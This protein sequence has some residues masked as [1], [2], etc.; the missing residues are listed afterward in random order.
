MDNDPGGRGRPGV[1][2]QIFRRKKIEIRTEI[3]QIIVP[4]TIFF[5]YGD[6]C[7]SIQ[8]YNSRTSGKNILKRTKNNSVGN[9]ASCSTSPRKISQWRPRS[10]RS[11]RSTE[12]RRF[13]KT[14]SKCESQ[15]LQSIISNYQLPFC[16][17]RL[18]VFLSI[19]PLFIRPSKP[20]YI[21]SSSPSK[22]N[23]NPQKH[24]ILFNVD[25]QR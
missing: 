25:A 9:F 22:N 24:N 7:I 10:L 16:L 17:R 20:L 13:L 4:K 5:Q 6:I 21:Q 1:C 23:L 2:P 14:D 3:C 12:G 11:V 8:R 18:A 15:I 19:Y